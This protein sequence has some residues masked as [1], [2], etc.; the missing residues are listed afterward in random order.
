MDDTYRQLAFHLA[1]LGMGMPT[2]ESLLDIL[3]ANLS[4]EEARVLLLLPTRVAPL[5]LADLDE[6]ASKSNLTFL[7]QHGATVRRTT[8]RGLWRFEDC[9]IFL[10]F[11]LFLPRSKQRCFDTL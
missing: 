8:T 6:I 9:R 11:F 1:A 3:K 7:G 5:Q 2:E 10:E 4:P